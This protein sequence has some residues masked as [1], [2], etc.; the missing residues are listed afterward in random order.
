MTII[1]LFREHNPNVGSFEVIQ[2]WVH[3]FRTFSEWTL[4]IRVK[5]TTSTSIYFFFHVL[6]FKNDKS[7]IFWGQ[8][9]VSEP[10]KDESGRY[11]LDNRQSNV[12]ESQTS[13][14]KKIINEQFNQTINAPLV[15]ALFRESPEG[16]NRFVIIFRLYTS[17]VRFVVL[18]NSTNVWIQQNE[19]LE[20]GLEPL[21]PEIET[22]IQV[23]QE[24]EVIT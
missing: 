22:V 3:D 20:E 17:T 23:E 14:A 9:E 8:K 2:Q 4:L 10:S 1:A 11:V 24:L 7:V 18:Q 13:V 19:T 21:T 15:K 16:R 5:T 12:A 6:L